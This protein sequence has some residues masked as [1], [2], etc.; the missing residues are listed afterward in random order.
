MNYRQQHIDVEI[1][2][3]KKRFE[4][5]LKRERCEERA[6]CSHDDG[7]RFVRKP[8]YQP[9]NLKPERTYVAQL[10]QAKMNQPV[11]KA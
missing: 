2:V 7:R 6:R 9:S 11:G 10:A 3:W 5:R 4:A 8:T 1:E